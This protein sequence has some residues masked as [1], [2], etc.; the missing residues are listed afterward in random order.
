MCSPPAR[1]AVGLMVTAD[2]SHGFAGLAA[3]VRPPVLTRVWAD[4]Q[5]ARMISAAPVR[6]VLFGAES[7]GKTALAQLLA[8][9]FSEP[10]S[11]EFVREFW[12]AHRGVITAAD[13][14][15]IGRGQLAAEA[16]AVARARRAVFHDT[17]LLTCVLWDDLLFPGACPSWVRAEAERRARDVALWLL[18]DTDL[19]WSPDPQ[20]CFPDA[21]GRAMC[22]Q[23]WREALVTRG[24]PFVDIQGRGPEREA[25]AFAAVARALGNGS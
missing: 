1:R 3:T 4:G 7:T 2:V 20:R 5:L 25:K 10:W 13:L 12:E 18:C 6:I 11:P 19:P 24:L 23:L 9:R 8:A 22:R 15:A 17:E 16:T 14:D 21:A